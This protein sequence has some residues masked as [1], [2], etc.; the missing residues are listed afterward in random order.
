MY[1]GLSEKGRCKRV[2]SK[3]EVSEE[4]EMSNNQNQKRCKRK[5]VKK[6]PKENPKKNTKKKCPKGTYFYTCFR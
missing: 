3:E 6:N 4:C 5:S 1:C 2:F